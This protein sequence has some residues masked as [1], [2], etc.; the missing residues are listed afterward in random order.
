MIEYVCSNCG[1]RC[2]QDARMGSL[3]VYLMCR[4]AS[5]ENSHWVNDGR[6]GYTTYLNDAHPVRI[7]EYHDLVRR[8]PEKLQPEPKWDNW[9][10]DDD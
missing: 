5:P 6:G 10:R 9:S 7:D 1:T 4:C 2:G 8:R 3:D